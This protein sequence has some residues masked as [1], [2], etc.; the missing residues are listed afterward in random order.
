VYMKT[1]A[2]VGLS[3]LGGS[4]R[5]RHADPDGRQPSALEQLED[6]YRANVGPVSA[7]FARRCSEPKTVA[8]LTS[9]TFLRAAA[10]FARFDPRRGSPRAWL[11]GIASRVFSS[12]CA[13][14]ADGVAMTVRL[15]ADRPL[16]SDEIEDL[17]GR[18]DAQREGR[19]LLERC[20][21]LSEAERA[22]IELVDVAG[23]T[24]KEAAN[25]LGVSAVVVRKRLSRARIV[26][27][28]SSGSTHARCESP[29]AA[30]FRPRG[31][32]PA[33]PS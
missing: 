23:L 11:F 14:H 33:S 28:R 16:P 9:E 19:E 5:T 25:A 13:A 4:A 7:Y 8:D 17:A 20:A 24:P 32:S 6:V 27:W 30:R 1:A 15:A 21:R 18:I 2:S 31:R 29:T 3:V 22:A 12:Y 10:G 26:D